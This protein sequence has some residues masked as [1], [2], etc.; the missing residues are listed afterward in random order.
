MNPGVPVAYLQ[1][2]K[3]P[4]R[5]FIAL[6]G[7]AVS[8]L[9]ILCQMGFE[10]SLFRSATRLFEEFNADIALTEQGPMLIEINSSVGFSN[11]FFDGDK[12]DRFVQSLCRAIAQA[13][14]ETPR[15]ESTLQ[16]GS[17]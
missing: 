3:Q 11:R 6:A 7:I 10:D 17:A 13:S 1:L 5:L 9:G 15:V 4:R 14:R 2:R 8:S 12:P 16:M